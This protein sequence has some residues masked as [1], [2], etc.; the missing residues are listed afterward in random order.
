VCPCGKRRENAWVEL[1]GGGGEKTG[2]ENFCEEALRGQRG[3]RS[4]SRSNMTRGDL[5]Q[6]G[7]ISTGRRERKELFEPKKKN[8]RRRGCINPR[9]G[10]DGWGEGATT[11]PKR[12]KPQLTRGGGGREKKGLGVCF[13]LLKRNLNER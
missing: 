13:F 7:D 2:I 1:R 9:K 6:E 5:G 10:T 3:K 11:C 12:R 4:E 8:E